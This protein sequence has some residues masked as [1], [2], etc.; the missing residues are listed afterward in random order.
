MDVNTVDGFIHVI[1]ENH[2]KFGKAENH[3]EE[4]FKANFFDTVLYKGV[5]NKLGKID[6][7]AAL[8][9]LEKAKAEK[10]FNN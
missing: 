8:K 3:L 1:F 7:T 10:P 2:K 6:I 9:T 5:T 4:A